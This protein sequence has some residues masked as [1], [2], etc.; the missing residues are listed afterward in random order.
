M[1]SGGR[2]LALVTG[3]RRRDIE[4]L[5]SAE[6]LAFFDAVVCGDDVQ[7]SKP[8]P[9]PFTRAVDL[10]GLSSE[11]VIAIDNAPFGLRAAKAAGLMTIA[12]TTT[13]PPEELHDADLILDS[14]DRLPGWMGLL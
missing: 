10:L 7:N 6:Q 2:R 3:S 13:L 9:E 4:R 11:S 8:D 14:L 12:L 1:K 5:L